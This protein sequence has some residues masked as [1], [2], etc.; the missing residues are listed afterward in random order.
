MAE[1]NLVRK[2]MYAADSGTAM[3]SANYSKKLSLKS[4]A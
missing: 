2:G 3:F 1:D 4:I